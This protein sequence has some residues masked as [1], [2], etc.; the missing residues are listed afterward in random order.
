MYHYDGKSWQPVKLHILEGGPLPNI[1]RLSAI[2]GFSA[3]HIFVVGSRIFY[4][5]TP[6]PNFLD[7]SLMIRYDGIRW[8]EIKV[9]EGRELTSVWGS[10]PNDIWIGGLDGVLYHYDGA[11]VRKDSI[12]FVIPKQEPPWGIYSITGSSR[13]NV[14]ALLYAPFSIGASRHYLLQHQ[15]ER[16]VVVDSILYSHWGEIWMSPSGRLYASGHGG[17]YLRQGASW[18]TILTG[19]AGSRI[20]GTG[21]DNLYV[22]GISG[23]ES[24]IMGAVYHYNGVDWFRFENLLLSDVLYLG[25]WTDGREVFIVGY[26]LGFPQKT[27]VL[28]GR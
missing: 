12:P 28:H 26:T 16:W 13:D 14:Y 8:T 3:N 4:N 11:T 7:S 27:V 10:E 18:Q 2:Y 6:P 23:S 15:T 22:L 19:F 25:I 17:A 9:T 5:P 24:G 21:D 20:H 1:G